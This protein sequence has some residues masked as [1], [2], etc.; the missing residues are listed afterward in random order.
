M[1]HNHKDW[2]LKIAKVPLQINFQ[3]SK[4]FLAFFCKLLSKNSIYIR[5]NFVLF[6]SATL[7]IEITEP[8]VKME[9]RINDL[10]ENVLY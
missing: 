5:N 3:H 8:F 4:P 1:D 2:V 9:T 10:I 6:S 7:A